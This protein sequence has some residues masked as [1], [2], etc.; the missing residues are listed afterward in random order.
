[1]P[2]PSFSSSSSSSSSCVRRRFDCAPE[3]VGVLG[4]QPEYFAVSPSF[5]FLSSSEKNAKIATR[6]EKSRRC[7]FRAMVV[8]RRN[9]PKDNNC[10]FSAC[11]YLCE[12]RQGS[13]CTEL[14]AA[15]ADHVRSSTDITDVLLGMPVEVMRVP[16]TAP[17]HPQVEVT[18]MAC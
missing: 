17:V 16:H 8:I 14:R 12:G 3:Q 15:V 6:P 9:I 11:G 18:S 4:V 10:L 5:S 13:I 7:A 1:V 2:K